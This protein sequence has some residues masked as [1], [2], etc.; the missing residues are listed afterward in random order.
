VSVVARVEGDNEVGRVAELEAMVVALARTVEKLRV[1]LAVKDR[2]IIDQ[3]TRIGELERA[4]E[5]SRRGGK[6][7][8]AP[9]SKG[10][11]TASPKTPGRKSGADHGRHGH[12]AT[13]VGRRTVSWTL[14]C[15]RGARIVAAG[16][17]M[18]VSRSSGR[19]IS[20]R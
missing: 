5:D 16:S 4:L 7:Q 1:E 8:A 12:R 11:P 2:V 14:V 19:S 15:L 20:R 3:A 18:T 9:F 13:P 17:L 10:E 6:R